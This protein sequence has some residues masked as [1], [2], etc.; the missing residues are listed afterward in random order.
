MVDVTDIHT[1]AVWSGLKKLSGK[2]STLRACIR[3]ID[4]KNHGRIFT[5]CICAGNSMN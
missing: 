1:P 4:Y 3:E 2:T 5:S